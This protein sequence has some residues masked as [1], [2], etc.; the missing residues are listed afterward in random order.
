MK[1]IVV[2]ITGASGS[3]YAKR[4]IEELASKG[5]LVHV[6]ATDKG[7]Q[8]F[9]YE[10]S[11][12]LKQWIRE[13]N[14]PTVKLEDNQN[15]FAGVASGSHGFDAVIVMPCSMGTLAEISHGL[16]RNLLCR[17]ADVALKEGRKLIIVPRETPFNTIH[18]ENMC[19]LSKV[20]ATIIPAMP[21]FYHHPQTLEDLVNFVV[22]KVLSYLNI[23]HN[24]FKKWEDTNYED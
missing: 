5:Y 7:K 19:H 12:D 1:K 24:L 23:N 9:K 11:L 2:G 18:L 22:G 13:L 15:L 20:G 16:S 6:I 3:I 21:G 8:V 17:A 14:Q 10:L 4:L